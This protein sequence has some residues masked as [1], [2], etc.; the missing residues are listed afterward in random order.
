MT[1]STPANIQEAIA[2]VLSFLQERDLMN[3]SNPVIAMLT[4]S[5]NLPTF[6]IVQLI[7]TTFP[8]YF[9]QLMEKVSEYFPELQ[10]T[11]H[12]RHEL[13]SLYYSVLS[14]AGIDTGGG[15]P[16]GQL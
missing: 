13:R 3:Q 4:I 11:E 5:Q 10:M 12:E 9:S 6:F 7:R 15:L 2:R 8:R 1:S 16:S 14:L